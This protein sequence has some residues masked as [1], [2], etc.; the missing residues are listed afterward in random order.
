MSSG[1]S[2]IK[3]CKRLDPRKAIVHAT[4]PLSEGATVRYL[5][6]TQSSSF[7]VQAFSAGLLSA[8]AHNPKIAIP[9]FQGDAE[10][11]RAGSV[12]ENARLQIRINA[13]SLEVTDDISEKDREEINS[14]MRREV[15]ETDSYPEIV[16]DCPRITASGNGDRFWAAL[17]GN[18]S[19]RGVTKGLPISAKVQLNGD[20]LRATGE[21]SLRQSDYR[22]ALISA[23]GGTI[24]LKD[25]L[26]FMFEIVARREA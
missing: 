12:L 11:T 15:L 17:S 19:L 5:I 21:F 24:R 14:R 13:N 2:R 16:Y 10:F 25:E 3:G 6:D 1:A 22:I 26:K 23:A 8:F 9:D 4:Q 20:S 7:V 18:L